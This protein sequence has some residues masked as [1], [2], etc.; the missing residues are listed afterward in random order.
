MISQG[1]ILGGRLCG[2]VF[3]WLVLKIDSLKKQQKNWLHI[4]PII[5]LVR[6]PFWKVLYM[7]F[8]ATI[9]DTWQSFVTNLLR[10]YSFIN[11]LCRSVC[12]TLWAICC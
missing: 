5:Y 7:F 10:I 2:N 8:S 4:Y 9:T 6:Q 1:G 11:M 12:K 3:S